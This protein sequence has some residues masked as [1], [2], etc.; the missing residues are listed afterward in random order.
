MQLW[1]TTFDKVGSTESS[2]A[3]QK[4]KPTL[5][6]EVEWGKENYDFVINI[7]KKKSLTLTGT[8]VSI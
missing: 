4:K 5:K 7:T 8:V 6:P 2:Q 3:T 1:Y